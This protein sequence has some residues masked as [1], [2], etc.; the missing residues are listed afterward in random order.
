MGKK[1]NGDQKD[2]Q[3]E[4]SDRQMVMKI[5]EYATESDLPD[6]VLHKILDAVRQ[7]VEDYRKKKS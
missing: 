7:I 2:N 4:L 5:M 6:E 1:P 3:E